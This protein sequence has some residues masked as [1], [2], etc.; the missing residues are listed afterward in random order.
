MDGWA[1]LC[2]FL[3]VIALAYW[4]HRNMPPPGG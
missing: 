2:I 4:A 1:L 3:G